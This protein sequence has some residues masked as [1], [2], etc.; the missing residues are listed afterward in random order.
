MVDGGV[1]DEVPEMLETCNLKLGTT[2][3]KSICRKCV[4][5]LLVL[6]GSNLEMVDGGVYGEVPDMLET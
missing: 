3:S 1:F 4:R 5:N 6:Q 2:K